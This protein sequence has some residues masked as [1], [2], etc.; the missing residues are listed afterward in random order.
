VSKVL[1]ARYLDEAAQRMARCCRHVIQAVLRE[2]EWGDA[3]EEFRR[4]ILKGL[5]ELIRE[6]GQATCSPD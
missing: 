1:D 4:V 2:E 6:I 3:D 5:E